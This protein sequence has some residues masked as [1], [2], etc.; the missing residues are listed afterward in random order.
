MAQDR[1][2]RGNDRERNLVLE[3]EDVLMLAIVPFGPNA[4]SRHG[5]D[6]LPGDADPVRRL[7]ARMKRRR[8]H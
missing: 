8:H 1:L 7:P 2:D 6:E 5:V 4:H 3:G